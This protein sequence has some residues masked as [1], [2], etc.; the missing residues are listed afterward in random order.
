MKLFVGMVLSIGLLSSC[1]TNKKMTYL[2]DLDD[3]EIS[4][5]AYIP[6]DYRIQ[7]SDNLFIRVTT[8]DPR[9]SEMFN[10]LPVAAATVSS[11]E[12]SVDLLSYPVRNDGTVDIPYL[13]S[14][15]LE[16]KTL[17]EA[18]I[19]LQNE[20]VDYITDASISVK[21]VNNYLSILGEVNR[22]GLYPI[23]KEKLNI[24]Q[25]LSMAGDVGI[26]S[27]R[28]NVSIIRSSPEG[29]EVKE[30]DLRDRNIIDSEYYYIMPNDV[31]YVKP[32]KGRF[33][34]FSEFPYVI[35]L[36]TVTTFILVLNYIQ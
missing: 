20:L 24:F 14:V 13:G 33:W 23:Y 36:T 18:K 34:A 7:V 1:V 35:L 12:Q 8:P 31:I 30:F 17:T 15:S 6:E 21:L 26:L 2:Q 11:T 28:Y 25:A 19:V 27:S 4:T 22:P 29:S 9:F 32:M 16:G 3:S 5:E 10:T